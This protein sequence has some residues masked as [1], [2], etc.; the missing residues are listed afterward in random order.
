MQKTIFITGTSSGL[1]RETAL[2]FAKQGWNVAATM[3][4]PE[5]E[6]ELTKHPNIRVFRLDVTN[7]GQ[8][9][10]AIADAIAAFGR[11][12]V[13]VNNA[14][15]GAYGALELA[16]EEAIDWQFAVNVRGPINIIRAFL[17]HFR[18][19]GGGTFI[20]ISSFMGLTVAVPLGSLYAMSKFALE[21]LTEGLHYELKPQNIRIHLVEQGG[22]ENTNFVNNVSW[23]GEGPTSPNGQTTRKV[24]TSA[25]NE[26]TE[27][28]KHLMATAGPEH[29]SHPQEIIDVIYSLATGKNQR[30]RNPVGNMTRILLDMRASMPIEEYLEKIGG[31]FA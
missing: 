2:Y 13:V 28:L 20:N 22:T 29:K 11:I 24:P 6:T 10:S 30:F 17:P 21:G 14:G 7:L 9:S 31:N 19:N 1:G 23:S 4:S 26:L 3:R 8:V 18:N 12:D 5:K 15:M 27:K 25:Y 16:S